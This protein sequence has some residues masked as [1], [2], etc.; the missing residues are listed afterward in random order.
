M[1]YKTIEDVEL[2]SDFSD[3]MQESYFEPD[4]A[5]GRE[6]KREIVKSSTSS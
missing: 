1:E 4:E 6:G 3:S 5:L 2:D